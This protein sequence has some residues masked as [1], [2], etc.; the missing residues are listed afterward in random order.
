[1]LCSTTTPQNFWKIMRRGDRR[2]SKPSALG[3]HNAAHAQAATL[4]ATPAQRG[5]A[6]LGRLREAISDYD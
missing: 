1:V 2:R 3:T 6:L 4:G 5:E